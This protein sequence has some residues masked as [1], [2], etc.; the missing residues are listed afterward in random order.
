MNAPRFSVLL[1]TH[2]R[3][4]VLGLAIQSVLAQ[5]EPDFE[6]LIVADGCSDDTAEVVAGFDDP[7]IRFFDL[8]KA[9]HYGYAN[10]NIALRQAKGR[11]FA[12]APH[13][14]LLMADH[15]SRMGQ[16]MD[17]TGAVWGY[18]QPLWVSTDGI[19]VPL[20]TNLHHDDEFQRF[21]YQGNT[22]PAACIV[23][24]RA[25]LEAAN[26]WP[27]DVPAAADWVLWRRMLCEQHAKL[28]HLRTPTSL[29]FSA[30]WKKSRYSAQPEVE[31]V[32]NMA[33]RASWWPRAMRYPVAGEAEQASVW[34]SMRN[35]G[36]PWL[37]NLRKAANDVVARLA[38]IAAGE[39]AQTMARD[40]QELAHLRAVVDQE[41]ADRQFEINAIRASTSWRLT[42]PLRAVKRV[43]ARILR[44]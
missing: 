13:D 3:A 40:A 6:L 9:P 4:D 12:F 20:F 22:I 27:E 24:T 28:A 25:A 42:A 32:V 31:M 26:Y 35:G 2:N 14:D 41:R 18:S 33:E 44:H 30:V 17:E 19:I 43:A 39:Y 8:P 11:L 10:R 36:E 1:P 34:R 23:H 21:M 29:H 15:L 37:E 38:L 16:L 7:R 5:D